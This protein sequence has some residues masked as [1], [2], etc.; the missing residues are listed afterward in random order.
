MKAIVKM[1]IS[2][3]K[4]FKKKGI[5][6]KYVN[7]RTAHDLFGNVV[8]EDCGTHAYVSFDTSEI[9]SLLKSALAHN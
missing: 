9:D 1:Q 6:V 8:Y 3:I 4:E 7:L 2:E 5:N